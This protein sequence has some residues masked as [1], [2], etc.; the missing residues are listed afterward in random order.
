MSE[1][2]GWVSDLY[3]DH[4]KYL[5]LITL[6]SIPFRQKNSDKKSQI[7]TK[8]CRDCKGCF[9][10]SVSLVGVSEGNGWMSYLF[11]DPNKFLTLITLVS[12][13]SRQE[14]RPVEPNL[15]PNM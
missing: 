5:T 14:N 9:R 2:D 10:C 6:I 11:H 13:P 7:L 12:N 4:N 15:N 3:H 8:T 1:G